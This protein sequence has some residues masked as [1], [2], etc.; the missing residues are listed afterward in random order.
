MFLESTM[1]AFCI[2]LLAVESQ[3]LQTL[4]NKIMKEDL[5][6][7]SHPVLLLSL[8]HTSPFVFSSHPTVCILDLVDIKLYIEVE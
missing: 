3:E 5:Y 6:S 7:C 8:I 2:E 1:P 4:Q